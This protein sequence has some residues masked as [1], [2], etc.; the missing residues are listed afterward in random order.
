[1]WCW[2]TYVLA[3]CTHRLAAGQ[4]FPSRVDFWQLNDKDGPQSLV[5]SFHWPI[6]LWKVHSCRQMLCVQMSAQ[7]C[8]KLSGELC[9]VVCQNTRW[10]FIRNDPFVKEY[11]R[12]I[13]ERYL[14]CWICSCEF[15]IL[16]GNYDD[17]LVSFG[18]LKKRAQ[19]VRGYKFQ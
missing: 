10:Y 2:W 5:V 19:D 12:Y 7:C 8:N 9:V 6:G 3:R 18:R 1:M 15:G 4:I 17:I 16:I 14:T 13:D 11:V